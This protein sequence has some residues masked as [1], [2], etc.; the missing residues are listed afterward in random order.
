MAIVRPFN[1]YGPRQ[2]NRA[3][4]PTIITQIAS[5]SR[6]LKLGAL[7]PT[8]DFNY[9]KDTVQGFIA[10]MESE[11]CIGEVVNIGSNFET[12]IADTVTLISN[13]MGVDVE[14]DTDVQRL[15]PQLSEVDRLWADNSKAKSL[16][17]WEPYYAGKGGL[18]KGLEETVA[19]FTNPANLQMYKTAFY[20]L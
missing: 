20:N 16:L 19:W 14:V 6:I 13:I 18:R 9:V 5:G 2:S 8:R 7:H 3:V 15:R 11:S 10:A 1:T 4:I 12:S 17:G